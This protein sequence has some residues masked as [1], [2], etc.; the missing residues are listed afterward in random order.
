MVQT[1]K[2]IFIFYVLQ[3]NI[4]NASLAN[5]W[6]GGIFWKNDCKKLN[7][8]K[9]KYFWAASRYNK[10]NEQQYIQSE[11]LIEKR[12]VTDNTPRILRV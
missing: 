2:L 7:G 6:G 10:S 11:Y 12:G 8:I 5:Q 1:I 3:L 4:I 9:I